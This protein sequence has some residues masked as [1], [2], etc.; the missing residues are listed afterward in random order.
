MQ[1]TD[2]RNTSDKNASKIFLLLGSGF[3]CRPIRRL[4]LFLCL[5]LTGCAMGPDYLRPSIDTAERFRIDQA[6]GQSIANI[7][8]WELLRDEELQRLINQA[9]RENK[10]LKRAIASVEEFEARSRIA[11]M[12]FVPNMDIDANAPVFGKL[13]GFG[14]PGFPTPFSYFGRTTLNWEIDIW[15]RI[16]RSNQAARADLMAREENRRAIVLALIS[17]VAQS[18]FDLLQFDIQRDIAY[19]ALAS[20]EESVA[21]SRAQLQGGVISRLDLDQFEAERAN[22]A[23]RVAELERNVV[24]KE[25]ELS[26]LLGRNPVSIT[27]GLSLT[28]QVV[29]P[30]VP[31]GLPSELLQRRPDILQAEQALAAATARIGM[32]QASRFPKFSITGMLGVASPALS[33]LLLSGSEFG[34]GGLG[35]AGP[36]L[37]AQSLGFE[38]RA[39]EA[40][41]RQALAHYEQT[42][43][44]AFK[45]VE[46]ALMAIR[47]ANDQLLA[48]QHQVE[49]L[50][51]ALHVADLRYQ[52]GITSYVDVLLAKRNLFDAEFALSATQRFRLTSVVQLYK[53][54]GGGWLP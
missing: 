1:L 49:A 54:L 12:D 20:W 21:I 29:P 39:A 11:F 41:A 13:S 48:Q 7:P 35:L 9:L 2:Y 51:S 16:R 6:E 43:L 27:R 5:W 25:N 37:N 45:E 17:A 24:Q 38:Q 33:N 40:Q 31:A 4:I 53:A 32:A 46:D 47:T 52:G 23:A 34:V 22:A 28:E 30:E 50:H 18:Y 10:D 8:W 14:I 19:R 3:C 44:L 26:V 36:L 42:I 15:G